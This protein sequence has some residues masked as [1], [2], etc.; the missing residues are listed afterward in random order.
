MFTTVRL[1]LP[2]LIPSWRFFK[3]VAP[4]PRVEFRLVEH[5][6]PS[7]WREADPRPPTLGFGAMML[8]LFWNAR[9]SEALYLTTCAERLIATQDPIFE[10][11]INERLAA[12]IP[13]V[14]ALLQFRLIFVVRAGGR[15]ER[16][17]LFESDP[18]PLLALRR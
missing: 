12:R 11:E 4:S 5:K 1:I 9:W 17:M 8:R 13:G 6:K 14:N 16:H 10:Q 2:A 3:T 15:I 7:A 18:A